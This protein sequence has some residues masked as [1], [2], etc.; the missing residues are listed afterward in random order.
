MKWLEDAAVRRLVAT[1]LGIVAAWVADLAATYGAGA[2][3][4][5]LGAVVRAISGL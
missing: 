1:I 5:H 4:Q 3:A 2:G